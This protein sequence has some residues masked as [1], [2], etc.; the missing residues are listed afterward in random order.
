MLTV[1]S[2][3]TGPNV[4]A[5]TTPVYT[6][7][8]VQGPRLGTRSWEVTALGGTV[9][10]VDIHTA[11]NPF[12][13]TCALKKYTSVRTRDP[14]TGRFIGTIPKN[15]A[16]IVYRKGVNLLEGVND[17]QFDV[18]IARFS[19]DLPAGWDVSGDEESVAALLSMIGADL[20]LN[21]NNYFNWAK[22]W[23]N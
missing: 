3:I 22:S 12:T 9:V 14:R 15:R 23:S 16:E 10:G 20:Y 4:A 8:E 19:I 21:A 7:T 11:T 5:L 18:A 6:F 17:T 2:P 1:T 13:K